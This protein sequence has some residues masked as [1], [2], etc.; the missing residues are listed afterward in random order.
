[1]AAAYPDA[2]AA[3]LRADLTAWLGEVESFGLL[4]REPALAA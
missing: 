2:P 3:D 4:R 1:V